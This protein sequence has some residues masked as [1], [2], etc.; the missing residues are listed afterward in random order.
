VWDFKPTLLYK[1]PEM[2]FTK[3]KSND[4]KTNID[5]SFVAS[6][7]AKFIGGKCESN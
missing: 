3:K 5:M 4:I 1:P 7:Y 2:D 6:Q